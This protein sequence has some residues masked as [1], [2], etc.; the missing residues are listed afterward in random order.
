MYMTSEKIPE[1]FEVSNQQRLEQ[2]IK[3]NQLFKIHPDRFVPFWRPCRVRILLVADSF[4]YFSDED[5]GLSDLIDILSVPPGPYVRF[6]ITVAHRADVSDAQAGIGNPKVK[7]SIENFSFENPS[8][9]TL[10]MYDE[11]WLFGALTSEQNPANGQWSNKPTERELRLL[12]EFMNQGGGVFATG[13][14]GSLGS[15]LC[16]HVPRVR[17]MRQWF[18]T[19]GP[20]GEPVS[21]HMTNGNRR[22]TNRPGYNGVFEFNDQSDD[23]PQI[24]EWTPYTRRISLLREIVFPHPLLCSP[25]GIITVM[26]DHPHEGECIEAFETNRTFTLDGQNFPEYPPGVSGGQPLPQLIAKSR[27]LAGNAHPGKLATSAAVFGSISVYDGSAANVGRVVCDSTWHHFININLTGKMGLPPGDPKSIGFLTPSGT[28]PYEEIKTYF[29]NIAVWIAPDRLRRCMRNGGIWLVVWQDRL[30]ESLTSGVPTSLS[31][32]PWADL[33]L[34]GRGA[35][36]ALGNFAGQCQMEQWAVDILEPRIPR[37]IRDII[38][39]W[40]PDPPKPEPNPPPWFNPEPLL[41]IAL[42]GAVVAIRERFP[43]PNNI[44]IKQAENEVEDLINS[45][46]KAAVALSRESLEQSGKILNDLIR[47]ER[48]SE[49]SERRT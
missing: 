6:E 43:D 19:P 5:F 18:S 34:I 48:D 39:P 9:F 17:S 11:V 36:D 37:K 46:V 35:R 47:G 27:V 31:K 40:P 25:R 49:Q 8:H 16:G 45:G 26:P 7:R 42:A 22:D 41:D 28:A 12:T 15:A 24:I 32:I 20:L 44:N 2:I 21:T 29:R 38:D 30:L 3:R 10:D 33:L 14:H 1:V 23:I 13:D 4:L